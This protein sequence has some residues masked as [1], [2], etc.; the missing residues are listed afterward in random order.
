MPE[1]RRPRDGDRPPAPG[2]GPEPALLGGL[3]GARRGARARRQRRARGGRLRARH[4]RRPRG[5]RRPGRE[6]D[7]SVPETA[8][9]GAGQPDAGA[10]PRAAGRRAVARDARGAHVPRRLRRAQL[11]REHGPALREVLRSRHPAARDRRTGTRDDA[12]RRGGQP[13]RLHAA[14]PRARVARA[15]R[16]A[17]PAELKPHLRDRRVARPS[18]SRERSWTGP[19]PTLPAAAATCSGSASGSTI[20]RRWRSTGSS[21][22]E[23]V[24]TH[25]FMLGQERQRDL[26]MSVAVG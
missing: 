16:R 24:G 5:R 9:Q 26:V 4:R 23:I 11:A 22:F 17:S 25:A 6:G 20:R 13:G 10:P 21:G 14:S 3:E 7:G 2:G 19:S 15:S 1:V 12:R 18:A 8:A